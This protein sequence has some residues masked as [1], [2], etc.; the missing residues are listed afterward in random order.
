MHACAMMQFCQQCEAQ[1]SSMYAFR[2]FRLRNR[3]EVDSA[4]FTGAQRSTG[5]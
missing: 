5:P 1:K 4:S 3:E 2:A